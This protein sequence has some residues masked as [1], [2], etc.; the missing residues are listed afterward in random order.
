MSRAMSSR[1]LV[2]AVL[3]KVLVTGSAGLI[4]SEA[5][6]FFDR[7]GFDVH[8]VD[9]NMRADFFGP[10]GDTTWNRQRLEATCARYTHHDLDIRDRRGDRRPRADRRLR[11]RDPRR[12][13]AEPRPGRLAALRRLRRERQPAP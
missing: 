11:A 4:G 5:V 7:L 12:R 10:G 9:N 8:G 1:S 2:P 13:P 3:V 6:E